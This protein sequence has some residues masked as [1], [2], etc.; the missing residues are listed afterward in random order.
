MLTKTSRG[1]T[2]LELDGQVAIRHPSK[3][4]EMY[5]VVEGLET[6]ERYSTEVE[7]AELDMGVREGFFDVA[8]GSAL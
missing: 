6:F 7:T 8:E 2:R 3:G 4:W 5:R 1:W